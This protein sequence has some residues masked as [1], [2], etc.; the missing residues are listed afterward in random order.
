MDSEIIEH[1]K[2]NTSFNRILKFMSDGDVVLTTNEEEILLRWIYCNKQLLQR[3]YTEA[4]IIDRVVSNFSVS[5]YTARNDI[6]QAQALFG[7]TI[8]A[9]KKYLL[10]HHAENILLTIERFKFDKALVFLLPKL[11]DSYTK[12]VLA[13]PDEINKDKMPPPTMNFF[14]IPGQQISSSKTLEDAMESIQKRSNSNNTIDTEFEDV[15]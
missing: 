10:Y 1:G 4:Q 7:S 13:M 3:K 2:Q 5:S 6:Y 14:V 11:L 15:Q 8:K 9:N 12:A